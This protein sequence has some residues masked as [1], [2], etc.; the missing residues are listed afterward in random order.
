MNYLTEEIIRK[1]KKNKCIENK[2]KTT[3]E[4]IFT[5]T[6][7]FFNFIITVLAVLV[8]TTRRYENLL[9]IFVIFI[10]T[11]IGIYQEIKSKNELE[12][13]SF[14][15]KSK[16]KVNRN[17]NIEEI[18]EYEIVEGEFLHL[19]SGDNIPCDG[20]IL[21]GEIEVNESILTGE[22]DNVFKK[23]KDIVL[24]GSFITS[25]NCLIKVDKV[26]EDS[27]INK[28]NKEAKIL[29][30]YPSKLRDYMNAILKYISF[31]LIPI[32]ILLYLK[33]KKSGLN[34]EEVVLKSV[35]ALIGMIPEGLILLTS[36]SLFVS[37]YK[38][39]KDKIL[40]QEL[41]CTEMLA[42]VDVL[43]FDKTG[44]I[45][46]G[47]ME[48]VSIDKKTK[49]V[50]GKYL[51]YFDDDNLTSKAIK[52]ILNLEPTWQVLKKK[53]FSSDCKYSYIQ[54]RG[55]GTY[56]FGSYDF[57]NFQDKDRSKHENLK[58]LGYRILAV[59]RSKEYIN[60]PKNTELI[61]TVVL[62]DKIKNNAR[63]T[64]DFFKKEAVDIKVISGDNPNCVLAIAKKAGIQSEKAVDMKNVSDEKLEEVVLNNNIFGH[65]TPVQK[66]KMIEILKNNK[67]T[68]AMVGDGVNDVLALK[69]ADISFAMKHAPSSVKSVSNI[70]L[71]TDNFNSFYK[72]L[73]EGRRVINNIS[74]VATLF[75]IKTF[76][77]ISFS[78]LVIVFAFEFPFIPIQFT[79]ISALTIGIPSFFLTLEE[80]RKKVQE[81]FMKKILLNSVFAGSIL[82]AITILANIFNS[83][84]TLFSLALLNGIIMVYRVSLPLNNLKKLLILFLS[85][86]SIIFI[87]I[88]S[89]FIEKTF[90]NFTFNN[91][92]FLFFSS[93]LIIII[94]LFIKKRTNL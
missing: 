41:Y 72:V 80:N 24:S 70:V 21:E 45:T 43:C 71:L 79:I 90:L 18:A 2:Y 10:N 59:S 35:G 12:K 20:T 86:F 42:R 8:A 34:Y 75:L 76:F 6:F 36:V 23:E 62:S 64:L 55:E 27:F 29:K 44:T 22:T 32:A 16:Y 7:T 94:H 9:F 48:V 56:F 57:L 78:F 81:D 63:E 73:M 50:L 1:S 89:L 65:T 14:L 4:I 68:V 17:N 13:L 47:D 52:K 67:K 74:K 82:L 38:L 11:M 5:N 83:L 3:K 61:G 33:G 26:G 92:I 28:I 54:V 66:K 30:K 49:D 58:N 53:S 51:S 31:F 85:T 93:L 84:N 77:S 15:S 46:T 25:G 37:A 39:A 40:V 88:N 91:L 19:Y 69:K 60:K 87:L